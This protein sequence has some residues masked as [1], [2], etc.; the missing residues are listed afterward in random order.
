MSTIT[1]GI[2]TSL[3]GRYA[4][5]LFDLSQNLT[6]IGSVA[7]GLKALH[8][9]IMSSDNLRQVLLDPTIQ[10]N[11]QVA[12]LRDVCVR[13]KV[14]DILQ[15]FM[16]QLLQARRLTLL[17]EIQIIYG[18]LYL[19]A[20]REKAIEVTSAYALTISQQNRLKNQI[21][22]FFSKTTRYLPSTGSRPSIHMRF[23][24]DP[25]VLGGVKVRI[26]S[27][28]IDAT[29]TTQLNQLATLMKGKPYDF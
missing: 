2:L 6:Q 10:R 11:Q 29:V 5:T 8:Q 18:G 3:A 7:K 24:N 12:V 20:K 21:S 22:Q 13:I 9:Q 16:V 28:I 17:A 1:S 26:G 15:S 25:K 4:R 14:P 27:Q 23:I 19:Q